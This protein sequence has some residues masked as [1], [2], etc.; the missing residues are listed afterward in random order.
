[1]SSHCA[2]EVLKC[3]HCSRSK[4][5]KTLKMPQISAVYYPKDPY[6]MTE[7]IDLFLKSLKRSNLF[8]EFSVYVFS[9]KKRL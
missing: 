1:M 9:S 8:V 3:L 5:L 4:G 7:G 2:I 6:K